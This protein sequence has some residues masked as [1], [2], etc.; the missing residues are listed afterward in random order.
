MPS[1]R[2]CSNYFRN[3]LVPRCFS[4]FIPLAV[5]PCLLLF[6]IGFYKSSILHSR[7]GR[8]L[9]FQL[10]IGLALSYSVKPPQPKNPAGPVRP[11]KMWLLSQ[12]RLC[13][14]ATCSGNELTQKDNADS[15]V[16]FITQAVSRQSLLLAKHPDRFLW[17][18]YIPYVYKVHWN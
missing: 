15:V 17:K 5:R 3:F 18:P 7:R 14:V 6:L 9:P 16:Q 8:G 11:L 13:V 12:C 1:S 4:W 10:S 2:Y